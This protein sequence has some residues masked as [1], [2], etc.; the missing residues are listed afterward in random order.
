MGTAGYMSPEQVRGEKLDAR[1]DLFSFGL[2]LYEMAVGQRAF[3]GE[4]TPVLHDAI[5]N[6]TPTS[7]RE[8]NPDLTLQVNRYDFHNSNDWR[9]FETRT[10]TSAFYDHVHHPGELYVGS[11]HGVTRVQPAKFRLPATPAEKS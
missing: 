7:V 5:L 10:I 1:T 3:T 8:L 4:T 6:H 2:V 9:F 11:N